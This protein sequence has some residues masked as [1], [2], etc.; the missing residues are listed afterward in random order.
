LVI[1]AFLTAVYFFKPDYWAKGYSFTTEKFSI[2]KSTVSGWFNKD[3]DNYEIINKI[4][5]KDTNQ[6]SET[7]N[8]TELVETDTSTQENETVETE[9]ENETIENETEVNTNENIV[10]NNTITPPSKDGRYYIIVGSVETEAEAKQE[11]KRFSGKGINTD[12]IYVPAMKRYRI[13]AGAFNSAK[14]AQDYFAELQKKYS[15]IE[16]WVWERK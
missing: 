7:I 1:G 9:I 8:E 5:N 10:E 4:D 15:K 2:V 11:Q 12:I 16:G 13:S 6:L 14:A 3:K